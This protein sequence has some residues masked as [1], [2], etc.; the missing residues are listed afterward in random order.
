[1]RGIN[2]HCLSFTTLWLVLDWPLSI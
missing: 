1:M 2:K